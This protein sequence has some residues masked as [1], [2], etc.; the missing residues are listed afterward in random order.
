MSMRDSTAKGALLILLALALLPCHAHAAESISAENFLEIKS[1][2]NTPDNL[3]DSD[4]LQYLGLAALLTDYCT[5]PGLEHGFVP[6]GL[7]WGGEDGDLLLV[8]GYV[9]KEEHA[10]VLLVDVKRKDV[11][12]V[13]RLMA[14]DGKP[15][16]MHAGGVALTKNFFW[17]PSRFRVRRFPL[18]PLM[19]S[20][21]TVVDITPA[22]AEGFSVDSLGSYVTTYRNC[23]WIGEFTGGKAPAVA[24]HGAKV[25]RTFYSGWAAGYRLT[26]D[27]RIEATATYQVKHKKHEYSVIKPDRVLVHRKKVQGMAFM[28]E[29]RVML[30]VSRGDSDSKIAFYDLGAAPWQQSLTE[31]HELPAGFSAERRMICDGDSKNPSRWLLTLHGPPGSE[32]VSWQGERWAVAFEGGARPY[33]QRWNDIEDRILILAPPGPLQ[34]RAE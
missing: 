15:M 7:D 22:E 1:Y 14:K 10:F 19:S 9:G 11:L 8:S 34:P 18:E 12:K 17:I 25:G 6:Q 5:V 23:L 27:E 13:G 33:R 4:R 16:S 3:V 20:R 21:E 29:R 26:S 28:D 30:S 31:Q 2:R 32:G 24:H